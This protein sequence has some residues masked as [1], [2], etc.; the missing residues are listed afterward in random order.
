[1]TYSHTHKI[2]KR[3]GFIFDDSES[4]IRM[5]D[6]FNVIYYVEKDELEKHWKSMEVNQDGRL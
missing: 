1:M 4:T 5:K 2:N 3:K 6:E